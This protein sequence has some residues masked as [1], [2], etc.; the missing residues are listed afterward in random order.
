M[1]IETVT[2]RHCG[3]RGHGRHH[4]DGC[5]DCGGS[6]EIETCTVCGNEADECECEEEKEEEEI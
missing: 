3:G 1:S 4:G 5:P 6:G 2:C